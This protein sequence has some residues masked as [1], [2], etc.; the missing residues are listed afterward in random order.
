[1]WN[2]VSSGGGGVTG[3]ESVWFS[4]TLRLG[5]MIVPSM[6]DALMNYVQECGVEECCVEVFSVHERYAEKMPSGSRMNEIE[7]VEEWGVEEVLRDC[8][9]SRMNGASKMQ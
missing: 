1:M 9:V 4:S 3:G 2:G 6:N 7:I 8:S 5:V